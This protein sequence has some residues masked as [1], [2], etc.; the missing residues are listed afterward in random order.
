[1]VSKHQDK[2][3]NGGTLSTDDYKKLDKAYS[4]GPAA[5]GSVANLSKVTKLP[6]K[7]VND[8]LEQ[9]NAHTKYKRKRYRFPR[10]TV[11]A[12]HINE[13][14]SVDVA[15]VDKLAKYNRNV[16][17][18]LV[19]VDVLSRYLRVEPM[20]DKSASEAAKAFKNMI[21]VK[22]PKMVWT[23]KGTEFKGEFKTL[24]EKRGLHWYSTNSET[25]SAF[26]ERNIRSLKA[27]IYKYLEKKWTWSY[28]DNLPEFVKTINT[29]VNR[30]T[31]L[32]P[33]KVTKKDEKHLLA[34]ASHAA[35]TRLRKPKLKIGD[36]VR[37]AKSD[38][39]FEK[40][41]QQSYSDEIFEIVSN[42]TINPPTYVIEDSD[43]ETI[44]GKFYEY[45]LSKIQK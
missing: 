18:L 2:K 14:W 16:K 35:Y 43:G 27:I 19:A 11:I 30:V 44:L 22:Q 3:E 13:I 29:R 31:K 25:K 1:M 38:I 45:E 4:Q 26:A 34:I 42:P 12:Y 39:A 5:F 24:C 36:L 23:D 15:Y 7:I 10:L 33:N 37:I 21:K 20:K 9:Q 8:Y 6:H 41:Y 40:G 32:A 28:I 17:Y